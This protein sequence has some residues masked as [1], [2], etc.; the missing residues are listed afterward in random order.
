MARLFARGALA[1]GYTQWILVQQPGGLFKFVSDARYADFH[2]G[3][4]P[5]EQAKPGEVL[6]V[7]VVLHL[8]DRVPGEVIFVEHRRFPVLENGRRDPESI[9]LELNLIRETMGAALSGA[10]EPAS[11]RWARRQHQA[12]FRWTP[13]DDEDQAIADMVSRRAKQPLL[14]GRVLRLVSETA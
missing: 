7:E 2:A 8:E 13:T 5:L 10:H 3:G 11:L 1:M 12:V 9:H 14:G 4:A 6:T